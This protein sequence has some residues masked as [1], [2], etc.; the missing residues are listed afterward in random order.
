M[1]NW[2]WLST[3]WSWTRQ[4]A[5]HVHLTRRASRSLALCGGGRERKRW[6]QLLYCRHCP[7]EFTPDEAHVEDGTR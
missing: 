3:P 1:A 4:P 2:P 7:H 6:V 5:D